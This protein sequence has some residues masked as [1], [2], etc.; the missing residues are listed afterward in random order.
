VVINL[1][2]IVFW[3]SA[4]S[5]AFGG[6][7]GLVRWLRL[8]PGILWPLTTLIGFLFGVVMIEAFLRLRGI[9]ETR[10]RQSTERQVHESVS[11][12][13]C[14]LMSLRVSWRDCGRSFSF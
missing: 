9:R 10:P 4:A 11:L 5:A 7:I 1:A 13:C 2:Y 6:G 3:L 8:P 14:F 12:T